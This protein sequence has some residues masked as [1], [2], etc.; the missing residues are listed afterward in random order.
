MI[1]VEKKK[2]K[3]QRLTRLQQIYTDNSWHVFPHSNSGLNL[4]GSQ[5]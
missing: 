4:A 2:K 3:R 5:G 1:I